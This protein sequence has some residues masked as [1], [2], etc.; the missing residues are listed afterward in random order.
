M[1]H[2]LLAFQVDIERHY[3]V[4]LSV[5]VLYVVYCHRIQAQAEVQREVHLLEV[6][7]GRFDF[8]DKLSRVFLCVPDYCKEA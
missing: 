2:G 3:D 6:G 4:D 5:F 1:Q 8:E 7:M